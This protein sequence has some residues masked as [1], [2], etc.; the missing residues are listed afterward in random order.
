[1]TWIMGSQGVDDHELAPVGSG[2]VERHL[3]LS[4]TT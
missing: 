3:D 2:L 4:A 1:M